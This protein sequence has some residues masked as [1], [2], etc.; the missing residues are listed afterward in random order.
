MTQRVIE[1]YGQFD[2][3]NKFLMF[4]MSLFLFLQLTTLSSRFIN[5][6]VAPH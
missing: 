3:V 4:F 6:A 5:H 2:A 1:C